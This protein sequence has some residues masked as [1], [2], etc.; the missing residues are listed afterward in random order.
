M[1]V[2]LPVTVLHLDVVRS[3]SLMN[4]RIVDIWP[5]AI[6]LDLL[7]KAASTSHN[8][9]EERCVAHFPELECQING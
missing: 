2:E 3:M 5:K 1:L 8:R 6:K 7:G 4:M 9:G